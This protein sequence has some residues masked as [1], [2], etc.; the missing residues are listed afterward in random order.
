[1]QQLEQN[2]WR[3]A[4]LLVDSNEARNH[5]ELVPMLSQYLEVEVGSINQ[6][7]GSS[8]IYPDFVIWGGARLIGINRKT[9]GEVLGSLDACVEQLQREI[10]GPCEHLALIV[11]GSMRP[12][13]RNGMYAYRYLWET[14]RLF[15]DERGQVAIARRHYGINPKHVANELT[16]LEFAGI[17][18]LHTYSLEDTVSKLVA[19]HD[20][21][22]K[23]EKNNTLERLIKPDINV[24]G[25]TPQET[26]FAKT[27]MGIQGAGVGEELS[28]T[29]ASLG[30]TTIGDLFR[31]WGEGGQLC[32]TF[33]REKQG[34]RTRRI[35]P[36][37]ESRL[38]NAL[39]YSNLQAPEQA[40]ESPAQ[41][42]LPATQ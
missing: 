35:G 23:G 40:G 24:R 2:G 31:L 26:A 32:D 15:N 16:R 19:F 21:A 8:L 12:S 4:L 7:P 29:I 9:A 25:L 38:Q 27:L 5:A 18:V 33:I 30:L 41:Y 1:M 17:Q 22:M 37:A 36:A 6:A 11:E 14:E 42:S 3:L 28:L 20:L 34:V 13:A 39:G 10:A